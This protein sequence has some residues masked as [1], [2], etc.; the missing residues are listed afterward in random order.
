LDEVEELDRLNAEHTRL[1]KE[2]LFHFAAATVPRNS[3]GF[4]PEADLHRGGHAVHRSLGLRFEE[5]QPLSVAMTLTPLPE[6]EQALG[7]MVSSPEAAV[8]LS[9]IAAGAHG[10][11]TSRVGEIYRRAYPESEF[12]FGERHEIERVL[13]A[14]LA[15]GQD[16]PRVLIRSM[17][18]IL[19]FRRLHRSIGIKM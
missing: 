2:V 7:R 12:G 1:A 14:S 9:K 5:D 4:D 17:V 11:L 15:A 16:D 10:D 8:R 6:V 3:L 18:A 19:D 13:R